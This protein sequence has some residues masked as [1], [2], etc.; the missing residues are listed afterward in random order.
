M[1]LSLFPA[2]NTMTIHISIE[3][4][5]RDGVFGPARA[6]AALEE[7]IMALQAACE[8]LNAKV[9]ITPDA[10]PVSATPASTPPRV[11]RTKAQI[12]AHKAE[13]KIAMDAAMADALA[14]AHE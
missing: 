11:R 3:P 1:G 4:E 9:T 10:M 13:A 6:L 2:E 5:K 12:A 7:P 8:A 14:P